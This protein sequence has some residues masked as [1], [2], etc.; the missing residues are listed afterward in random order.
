MGGGAGRRRGGWVQH[1]ALRFSQECHLVEAKTQ[2][3]FRITEEEERVCLWSAAPHK[4]HP[5]VGSRQRVASR[6]CTTS[7]S[8]LGGWKQTGVCLFPGGINRAAALKTLKLPHLCLSHPSLQVSYVTHS[9]F[10][11]GLTGAGLSAPTHKKTLV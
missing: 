9:S 6:S 5:S 11:G 8:N 3:E 1:N 2:K 10:H 7:S 4:P